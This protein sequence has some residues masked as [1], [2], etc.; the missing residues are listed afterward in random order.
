MGGAQRPVYLP[1]EDWAWCVEKAKELGITESGLIRGLI[2]NAMHHA[3]DLK[4]QDIAK[5]K[6]PKWRG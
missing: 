2:Q 3:E 6:R 5:A 4:I 1:D